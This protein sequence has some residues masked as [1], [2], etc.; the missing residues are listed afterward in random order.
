[1][2]GYARFADEHYNGNM[3]ITFYNVSI[4]LDKNTFKQLNWT[5]FREGNAKKMMRIRSDLLD[6]QGR[7]KA[8]YQGVEGYV[9][10][11][12]QH[13]AGDMQKAF[14][15]VSAVLG[16]AE[17]MRHLSIMWK[18]F[19]GFTAQYNILINVFVNKP[20]K[21]FIGQKGL[22]KVADKVF[23]GN[24]NITFRNVSTLRHLLFKNPNDFRALKWPAPWPA[25]SRSKI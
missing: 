3:V 12:D 5:H 21:Y 8:E 17:N 20:L 18:K 10:F 1:M 11:A 7:I 6:P 16:G 25:P 22:Q 14:N 19:R 2:E 24:I 23:K 13:Y 15:N 9:R 4:V